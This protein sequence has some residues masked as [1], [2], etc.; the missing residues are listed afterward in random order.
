MRLLVVIDPIGH[1]KVIQVLESTHPEFTRAAIT[2]AE[3]SLYESPRKGGAAVSARYTL[4]VPFRL[5]PEG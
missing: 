2:A 3:Q 5:A 4:R 1:V